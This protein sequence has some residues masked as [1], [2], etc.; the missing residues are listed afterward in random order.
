MAVDGCLG[1]AGASRN[2]IDADTSNT[3]FGKQ[4]VGNR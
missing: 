2:F 3:F 1:N 4:F